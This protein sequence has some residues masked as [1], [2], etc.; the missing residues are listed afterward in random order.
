MK[1]FWKL[2][3]REK[4]A[5]KFHQTQQIQDEL[6]DTM[7]EDEI[8]EKRNEIEERKK[9][10]LPLERR[11]QSQMHNLDLKMRQMRKK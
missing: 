6:E 11:Y 7:T 9:A 8:I 5:V 3:K 10:Q 2:K 4:P 1:R